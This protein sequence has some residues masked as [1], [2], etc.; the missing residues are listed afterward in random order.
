MRLT[1]AGTIASLIA[2]QLLPAAVLAQDARNLPPP[3]WNT[4][5]E[6]AGT[7]RCASNGGERRCRVRTDGRVQLLQV[8][9]GR[10][11]EN[12]DWDFDRNVI[13]VRNNCAAVFG[14]GYANQGSPGW[15]D[16]FAARIDCATTSR[17]QQRCFVDTQNRVQLLA[18]RS[19]RCQAGTSWGYTPDFIWVSQRCAGTFGYGYRAGQGAG[20]R[21]GQ[22]NNG[23]STGAIIGG[24]AVAAGLIA[25][26]ASRK[27]KN[28]QPRSG[29]GAAQVQADL[30]GLSSEA[31]PAVQACLDEAARQV[32]ATGATRLR[33]DGIDNLRR[34]GSG[35][36]FAGRATATYP[37][38]T[39]VTP[40]S[41]RAT[42]QRVD[43]L[44]FTS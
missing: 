16:D 17:A 3:G 1:A 8:E 32:G 37:D 44:Q 40:F 33:L 42:N 4:P 13:R 22:G 20:N 10:C 18:D 24:V 43:E 7:E 11:R 26:L 14:Y 36:S 35:W 23:P 25:L 2:T 9:R 38:E 28:A 15:N 41:C 39:Q 29:A 27:S 5:G 34:A 31:R 19:G 12:R 6:F 21:P 30:G